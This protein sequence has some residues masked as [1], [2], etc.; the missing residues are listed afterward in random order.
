MELLPIQPSPGVTA[1]GAS[2]R[3][4]VTPDVLWASGQM[5]SQARCVGPGA[6][7]S[8][9]A[10]CVRP[11]ATLSSGCGATL[12]N[13][14]CT[15]ALSTAGLHLLSFLPTSLDQFIIELKTIAI[16]SEPL[17]SLGTNAR[18][19]EEIEAGTAFTKSS[20]SWMRFFSLLRK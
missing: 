17:G 15:G 8:S 16:S 5:S 7:L 13:K 2:P 6:T 1:N 9:Q 18:F 10:G 3:I 14:H 11:G 19:G 4:Q 12:I 20:L